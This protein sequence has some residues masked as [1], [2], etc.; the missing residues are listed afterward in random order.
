MVRTDTTTV[1]L[2]TQ[3]TQATMSCFFSEYFQSVVF[4][5]ICRCRTHGSAGQTVYANK[6]SHPMFYYQEK[7]REVKGNEYRRRK[8]WFEAGRRKEKD[9]GSLRNQ[10]P[11]NLTQHFLSV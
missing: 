2:A 8:G 6:H 11:V 9:S 7:G 5:W 3:Y 10:L 1:D 4:G